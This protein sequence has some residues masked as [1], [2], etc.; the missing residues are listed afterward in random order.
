MPEA[1]AGIVAQH[2]LFI[3]LLVAAPLWDYY[4]TRRLKRDP[5]SARKL[6]Y[7]RTLCSWLWIST[8]V[9]IFAVGF[10]PLFVVN[11]AEYEAVWLFGHLWVRL[12]IESVLALFLALVLLPTAIVI[13]KKWKKQPRTW[14]SADALQSLGFFLPATGSERRWY[15]FLSITAAI[16]EETLFR[17]FLLHYL[18]VRPWRLSL[19]F[20]LLIAAVIFG[21][22]HVYL[23][24]SG[25]LTSTVTGLLFGLLFLLTGNLL[26]PIL[27][28]AALDL[29]MLLV[30]RPPAGTDAV[31]A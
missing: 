6:R 10:R 31:T 16:C 5:G 17:G 2:L 18:H 26:L 12:A 27:F 25:V 21:L 30:L 29:R 3:F 4:D 13:W 7:Y 22:Q 24:I 15:T 14:S 11:P 9:A 1:S 28:H 19:M 20:A 8:L 23:G